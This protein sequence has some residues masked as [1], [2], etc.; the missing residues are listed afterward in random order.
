MQAQNVYKLTSGEANLVYKENIIP[1]KEFKLPNPKKIIDYDDSCNAELTKVLL[2]DDILKNS[3]ILSIQ[4]EIQNIRNEFRIK[5]DN[6]IGTWKERKEERD[7]YMKAF[8][9][10]F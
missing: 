9:N 1:F 8:L 5:V 6:L 3:N 7:T 2:I 10:Q 4:S